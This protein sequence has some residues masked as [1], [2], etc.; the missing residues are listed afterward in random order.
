MSEE[1]LNAKLK[2]EDDLLNRKYDDPDAIYNKQPFEPDNHTNMGFYIDKNKNVVATTCLNEAVAPMQKIMNAFLKFKNE[3]RQ[4]LEL[5]SKAIQ[6]FTDTAK[7]LPTIGEEV[8]KL[9][10]FLVE[11]AK[12]P[13]YANVKGNETL[14]VIADIFKEAN[15]LKE[16]KE[17]AKN[18]QPKHQ[19]QQ[20]AINNKLANN[21]PY[22][23]NGINK[24]SKQ[25]GNNKKLTDLYEEAICEFEKPLDI[26]IKCVLD[27]IYTLL[28]TNDY[29]DIP[30]VI[31]EL[32]GKTYRKK[33][34]LYHDIENALNICQINKMP[35]QFKNEFYKDKNLDDFVGVKEP[36]LPLSEIYVIKGGV[37]KSVYKLMKKPLYFTYAEIKNQLIT[38]DKAY[39]GST[40]DLKADKNIIILR[41]T[42]SSRIED[43]KY[44]LKTNKKKNYYISLINLEKLLNAL[45]YGDIA[46]STRKKK[47]SQYKKTVVEMLENFKKDKLIKNYKVKQKA[48]DIKI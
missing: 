24:I 1:R 31:K 23:I 11:V 38:K 25:G 45:D 16:A 47:K 20:I 14:D 2:T 19:N 40:S 43:M 15:E 6:R 39:I 44:Q 48:I 35:I 29:F 10:P 5:L 30:M 12:K 8:S 36:I 42:L 17:N 34:N 3:S 37:K 9:M 41:E 22:L 18:F 32:T 13:K 46:E 26:F 27:K 7:L 21:L 28:K 33:F 4:T